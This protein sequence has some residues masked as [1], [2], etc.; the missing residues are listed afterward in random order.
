ML[1]YHFSSVPDIFCYF[2]T[3]F[4]PNPVRGKNNATRSADR[5]GEGREDRPGALGEEKNDSAEN[6]QEERC[7]FYPNQSPGQFSPRSLEIYNT[8]REVE[9]T[10]RCLKT[11]LNIRPI[12][13]QED[14][15]LQAHIYL[16]IAHPSS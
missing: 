8:I 14:E 16:I 2:S 1:S 5:R 12:H 6:R 7:L 10:F 15:R 13:H 4:C 3:F 9:S 11:D